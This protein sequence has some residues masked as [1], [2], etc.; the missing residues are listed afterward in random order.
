MIEI[1]K[2]SF[3]KIEVKKKERDK[4]MPERG[5][6][7]IE[8]IKKL[9]NYQPAWTLEKGYFEYISWYKSIFSSLK[10]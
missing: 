6:L 2:E 10:K 9:I 7:S 3:P 5:T 8:K 4:L 1:L